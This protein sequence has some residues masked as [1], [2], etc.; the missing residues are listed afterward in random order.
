MTE[1]LKEG[2]RVRVK[3]LE[4]DR[5]GKIRLSRREAMEDEGVDG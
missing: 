1:V 5:S 2:D 3:V 4:V